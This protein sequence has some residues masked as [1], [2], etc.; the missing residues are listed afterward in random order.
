M[1][2]YASKPGT[3]SEPRGGRRKARELVLRALVE[4][5]LTGD[6]VLDVLELSLGKFRLTLEGRDYALRLARSIGGDVSSADE[7]VGR[8]L[9]EWDLKRLGTVERAVLRLAYAELRWH[10]EV[11]VRVILDEAVRL[12]KRYGDEKA[13][14]FVNGVLDPLAFSLR[15]EELRGGP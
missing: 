7:A 13:G 5:D 6:A 3:G 14:S 9:L 11:E 10:G 4:S 2:R 1:A 15:P 12:A 8:L